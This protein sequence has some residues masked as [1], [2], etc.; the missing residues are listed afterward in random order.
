MSISQKKLKR[1]LEILSKLRNYVDINTL[2]GLYCALIY[3]FLK[4]GIIAL[5]NTYST[6]LKPLYVLQKKASYEGHEFISFKLF[7]VY[8]QSVYL[9]SYYCAVITFSKFDKH[10]I[11]L[12][13]TSNILK[14]HDLVPYQIAILMYRFKN[15]L[16]LLVMSAKF[17]NIDI[18]QTGDK[19][20]PPRK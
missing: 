6:T 7:S 2:T 13:K 14:L 5:G 17:L 9:L 12:H 18:S 11:P 4:Y 19:D 15:R 3:P 16:L 1:S 20:K 8:P 10:S